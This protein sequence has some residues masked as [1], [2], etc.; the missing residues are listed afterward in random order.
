[1]HESTD[2]IHDLINSIDPAELCDVWN[3]SRGAVKARLTGK[4]ALTIREICEVSKLLGART[5]DLL[6]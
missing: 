1:M 6:G 3:L 4:R 5:S 2:D